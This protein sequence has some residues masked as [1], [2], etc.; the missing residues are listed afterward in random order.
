[1]IEK[2]NKNAKVKKFTNL[3]GIAIRLIVIDPFSEEW[4]SGTYTVLF[5]YL[6]DIAELPVW[7]HST[8]QAK[9]QLRFSTLCQGG[10]ERR[11][12]ENWLAKMEII[13]FQFSVK[14]CDVKSFKIFSKK[15]T[16]IDLM[17]IFHTL[18]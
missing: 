6:H 10:E 8:S 2:I 18:I 14:W 12:S 16:K 17:T 1:M 7:N 11:G 3:L 13:L 5:M 9:V 4:I 15:K